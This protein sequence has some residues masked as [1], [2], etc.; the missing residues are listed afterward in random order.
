MVRKQT[1]MREQQITDSRESVSAP[2]AP[3]PGDLRNA[4]DLADLPLIPSLP[5]W[6]HDAIS[7]RVAQI[8]AA[9]ETQVLPKLVSTGRAH[10]ITAKAPALLKDRRKLMA[11]LLLDDMPAA[12]A[13]LAELS[14]RGI[15]AETIYT[16]ILT[17]V[18]REFGVYWT[19]DRCSFVDVTL[20]LGRLHQL[21]VMVSPDFQMTRAEPVA[22]KRIFL[23]LAPGEQHSFGLTMVCEYFHRA[24]WDVRRPEASTAEEIANAVRVEKCRVVGL[25]IGAE[26]HLAELTRSITTIRRQS[27]GGDELAI[28]VGG[29][30]FIQKPALAN[31]VGADSTAATGA[32]AVQRAEALHALMSVMD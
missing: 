25:S 10:G 22:A 9:V 18:A 23:A 27:A 5:Q 15:C 32:E 14:A 8:A 19:E 2:F 31:R 12:E 6:Q 11:L 13:V 1:S 28:M 20:A 7:R 30:L 21:M 4:P 17:P 29:P 26:D 3:T 24:G 16:G